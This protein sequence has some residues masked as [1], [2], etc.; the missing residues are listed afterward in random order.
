MHT[1]GIDFGTTK[2]LVARIH[3]ESGW[4][5]TVRLGR[6]TDAIPSSVFITD[7]GK[8][9]FGD[10]AEDRI[11][12]NDG[13][14]IRGFKMRLGSSIPVHTTMTE[15]GELRKYSAKLLTCEYLRYIKNKT[16]ELVFMGEPVTA[17]IITRPVNFSPAQCEELRQAAVEAGFN[18]VDFTTEPEAAGLAFC[19]LN[20]AKAFTRSALIVDWGGG[21]LDFALVTR[22]DGKICTHASLTDGDTT[23]G[24][25]RFDDK[26]WAHVCT[27]LKTQG[28][29]NLHHTA[30]LPRV[31]QSKEL[32]S[33]E[34]T[35]TLYLSSRDGVCPPIP[36]TRE[37]FNGLIEQEVDIAA[38]KVLE[39]LKRIP[40]SQAPEM[41]LLVGGSSRI[42]LIRTK[43]EQVCKLPALAWHFSHEAVALGAALW[44]N[45][46]SQQNFI[47][48]PEANTNTT[49]KTGSTISDTAKRK[50]QQLGAAF[51][52]SFNTSMENWK[53]LG[54]S[55]KE[56]M[57]AKK[58][59]RKKTRAAESEKK[60]AVTELPPIPQKQPAPM[61][62]PVPVQNPQPTPQP[63]QQAVPQPIPQAV[64]PVP[65]IVPTPGYVYMQ[66]VQP[67]FQV[68]PRKNRFGCFFQ[69]LWLVTFGLFVVCAITSIGGIYEYS[70]LKDI[71]ESGKDSVGFV[72]RRAADSIS[73]AYTT[74][75]G[76]DKVNEV[77]HY[78]DR[79]DSL[80]TNDKVK[81]RYSEKDSDDVI[82]T[83]G[84][85]CENYMNELL[86]I[87]IA[88]L[89][90]T[91]LFF[92]LSRKCRKKINS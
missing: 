35:T 82:I 47:P 50:V 86:G 34:Q 26:L 23:M 8:L 13:W 62:P 57:N 76:T 44:A 56:G 41:L 2:T 36:L 25:E 4:A 15:E 16:E 64:Q 9:H 27:Q 18:K 43:L 29:E 20:A 32:L 91:V 24:G 38:Q 81:I 61:L 80:K 7:D 71:K 92:W 65:V 21:T 22:E 52:E 39:L 12:N 30:M 73:V 51:K 48:T 89:V 55:I 53:K 68:H 11:Q 54:T 49:P 90:M 19:T 10:S 66:P 37:T 87:I 6:G 63:V 31:R 79:L 60:A 42:P 45:A 40:A 67:L 17:A 14:Y 69:L 59:S 3:T 84:A 58:E 70:E 83:T 75:D 88:A 78:I 46:N 28:V 74:E 77:I 72:T 5:R 33:S 1:I 85:S